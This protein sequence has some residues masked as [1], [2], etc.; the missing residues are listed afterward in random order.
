M[1]ITLAKDVE[2]FLQEQ[3][4]ADVC[5]G[6]SELAFVFTSGSGAN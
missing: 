2:D 1:T 3:L 4:R 6:A 5:A